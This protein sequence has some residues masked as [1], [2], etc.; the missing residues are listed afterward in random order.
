MSDSYETITVALLAVRPKSIK[1]E[2]GAT[3]APVWV[4]RSLLHGAD[5][6]EVG[7]VAEGGEITL[8]VR[9]WFCR[10]EGLA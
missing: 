4:P 7:R 10:R 1:V 5:D 8:R 3:A 2:S 9:E 6:A